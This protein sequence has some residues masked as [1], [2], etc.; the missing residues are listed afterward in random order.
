MEDLGEMHIRSGW[1]MGLAPLAPPLVNV[2]LVT[3][4]PQG[5]N[6]LDIIRSAIAGDPVLGPRLESAS[7]MTPVRVLGP[8]AADV[9]AI[10]VPGL[11]LAG[12]AAGFIDPMTGDGLHLAI[13]GAQL[14]A[15]ETLRVLETGDAGSAV[16]R[17][18]DARH[19][20]FG[21]KLRF[22][23]VMRRVVSTPG[24]V[25][26]ASFGAQVLPGA[27]RSAVRFAGDV[28]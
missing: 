22:N 10:G 9:S 2:C 8:L 12:D 20:Q 25:D 14:A 5:R 17:L 13:Q 24:A 23:R 28:A 7:F 6:P 27:I 19:R 3:P 18:A 15:N 11:L 16:G 26:L 21:G 1:Y 4:R